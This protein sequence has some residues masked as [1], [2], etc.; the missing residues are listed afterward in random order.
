MSLFTS[1]GVYEKSIE[2]FHEIFRPE[3]KDLISM[4][5]VSDMDYELGVRQEEIER[6]YLRGEEVEKEDVVEGTMGVS[7]D[8]TKVREKLGEQISVGG[9]KRYEIGFKD[10]KIAAISEVRWDKRRSA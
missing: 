2:R 8:A 4:R 6:V 1:Q 9:R 3:G 10:A 5:K 7:I